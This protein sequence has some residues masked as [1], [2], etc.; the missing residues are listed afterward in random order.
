[1]RLLQSQPVAFEDNCR[2]LT[3]A[4]RHVLGEPGAR[5]QPHQVERIGNDGGFVEIVD[6]PDGAPLP[7]APG[8]VIFGVGV[9]DREN[10]RS[11]LQRRAYR[12][13]APR[14]AKIG[15]TQEDERAFLHALVL[16][17][18]IVLDDPALLA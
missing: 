8:A 15:R 9:T 18:E 2:H 12:L 7:V 5:G 3:V 13:D 16:V 4:D 6:A 1:M 14:P 11:G 10:T 17:R